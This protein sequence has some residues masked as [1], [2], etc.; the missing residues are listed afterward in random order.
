MIKLELKSDEKYSDNSKTMDIVPGQRY[1]VSVNV[2]GILGKTNCAYFG[3]IY[4]NQDN[5]EIDRKIKWLNDFS[6]IEKPIEISFTGKTKKIIL[7]YRINFE[8]DYT[9]HLKY[10]ITPLKET[11][12]KEIQTTADEN[13]F[14]VQSV[15]LIPAA[16]AVGSFC[17]A[18]SFRAYRRISSSC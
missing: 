4:L 14:A 6:G 7:I 5:I 13:I 17:L 10:N 18:R 15:Q 9:S 11:L 16:S 2:T 8:T 12:L 1:S 3:V